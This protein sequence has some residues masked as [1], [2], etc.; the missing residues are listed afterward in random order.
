MQACFFGFFLFFSFGNAEGKCLPRHC[1]IS[2]QFAF[3][4]LAEE[5]WEMAIRTEECCHMHWLLNP[6]LQYL[7]RLTGEISP[8]LT[9]SWS[10]VI[11]EFFILCIE[12][13]NTIFSDY[14]AQKQFFVLRVFW[15]VCL[16]GRGLQCC[17]C[18]HRASVLF[19]SL[20][21]PN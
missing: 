2:Q 17:P 6:V 7:V 8:S 9:F 5:Q 21:V 12:S 10:T 1:E 4:L 19:I 11:P 16:K 13:Q 3:C 20:Q 14:C 18:L 15:N